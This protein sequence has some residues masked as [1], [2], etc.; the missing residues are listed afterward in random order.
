MPLMRVKSPSCV[1][2]SALFKACVL[3]TA[4][5]IACVLRTALFKACVLRTAV[6][7]TWRFH[8]HIED[9]N[10]VCD[11]HSHNMFCKR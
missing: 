11:I 7:W 2:R 1:L 10:T 9:K 3:R 8:L 4:F 6:C 5:F